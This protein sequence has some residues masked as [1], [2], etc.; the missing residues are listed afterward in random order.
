M[1]NPTETEIYFRG[2]AFSLMKSSQDKSSGFWDFLTGGSSSSSSNPAGMSRI[3]RT[4]AENK[5]DSPLDRAAR[6]Q[7]KDKYD[8]SVRR[9]YVPGRK[10]RTRE[11]AEA[12]GMTFITPR[13]YKDP[14]TRFVPD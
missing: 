4:E 2:R 5:V 9:D 7:G 14:D 3:Q 8:Y 12:A 1:R 10:Y 13:P 11:E 6:A